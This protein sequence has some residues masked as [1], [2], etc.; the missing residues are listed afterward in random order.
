VRFQH[1]GA[2]NLRSPESSEG[3]APF[4]CSVGFQGPGHMGFWQAPRATLLNLI[5]DLVKAADLNL[6]SLRKMV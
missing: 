3:L 5:Q 6:W 1:P 2:L 4:E